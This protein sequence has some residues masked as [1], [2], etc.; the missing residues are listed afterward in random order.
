[1]PT[2][3]EFAKAGIQAINEKKYDAAVKAFEGALALEPERPDMNSAMGM[4]LLHRGEAGAAIPYLEK[5]VEYSEPYTSA[6]H[7]EMKRHFRLGLATAYELVDRSAEALRVLEVTHQR[8]PD[9]I[10]AKLQMGQILLAAGRVNEGVKLYED[11]PKSDLL[12]KDA[13]EAAAAVVGAIRAFQESDHGGDVFLRAHAESYKAY[14]D[15]VSKEPVESGWYAEAARM[16]RGADGEVRPLIPKGA[17]SYAMQRIDLVDPKD[18]T[19]SGVYSEQDPMIVSLNGLEPLA[20]LAIAFPWKEWGFETLVS[21]RCPWHWLQIT[22]QFRDKADVEAIDQV[23]GPWYLAGFNGDFGEKDSGRFHYITDPEPGPH[24]TVTYMVDLGRAKYDAILALFRQL[25][26]QHEK[27]PFRRV[28][29]GQAK[30][31]D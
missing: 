24:E 4:A 23:M 29:L 17:R 8:G 21:S 11:L 5:A 15:D 13:K 18:G 14:F 25:M 30:V 28:L 10:E 19:A 31:I 16:A 9:K 2:L 3:D 1:M 26:V 6:E 20:Q 7:Q 27:T 12:D 22:F